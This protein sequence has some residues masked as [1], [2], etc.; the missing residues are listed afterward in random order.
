MLNNM[1]L[2]SQDSFFS[3]YDDCC[4]PSP[5]VETLGPEINQKHFTESQ[6]ESPVH[7]NQGTPIEPKTETSNSDFFF[8]PS[9]NADYR[10]PSSLNYSGSFYVETS[11]GASCSAETLL[12]MI[13]E[14]VGISTLPISEMQQSQ[15][16]AVFSSSHSQLE[17]GQDLPPNCTSVSALYTENPVYS[18][19]ANVHVPEAGIAPGTNAAPSQ[20]ANRKLSQAQTDMPAFPVVVKSERDTSDYEWDP[21]NSKPEGYVTSEYNDLFA[22]TDDC[23]PLNQQVD[24]K[25]FLDSLSTVCH[26]SD[27]ATKL[28]GSGIPDLCFIDRQQTFHGQVSPNY[29]IQM[30]AG[31]NSISTPTQTVAVQTLGSQCTLDYATSMLANAVDSLLYPQVTQ[32]AFLKTGLRPEKP[33][34]SRKC[35]TGSNGPAKEKPFACPMDNCERR[36]SRSDELNRHLR[37]HT[38]HKPF[39]CRIC[40]RSFSRSDHLTTHTRTHTGEKPFSCDVC[41]R[42]FARSDE[43]KRHGRVHLKQ[44]EKS[45]LKPQLLTACSF[46]LPQGF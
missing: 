27:L 22:M 44:K 33:S 29:Q 4:N 3:Q 1:D 11:S 20:E 2:N 32:T 16:E 14:I 38:G 15:S 12:N 18:S 25:D 39:Q 24:S 5:G 41:G 19:Y 9:E 7:F 30:M 17:H 37:I 28:E 36:F 8:D 42:R 43:R 10:F 40:L 23:S 35:Q 46:S 21:F 31:L 45:E 34:R 13:S 6:S 26:T